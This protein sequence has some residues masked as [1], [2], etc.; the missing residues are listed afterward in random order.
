MAPPASWRGY[1][2]QKDRHAVAEPDQEEDVDD[3][4][5]DP[6]DPAGQPDP[7]EIGDPRV[8][9]YRGLR[10]LAAESCH[11]DAETS[12]STAPIMLHHPRSTTG[13]S[14]I[15]YLRRCL[16]RSRRGL[17]RRRNAVT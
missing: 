10:V 1:P 14:K 4:P 3:A 13:V 15:D 2:V 9:A 11:M 16:R 8:P 12:H 17:C 6:G 7:A 5:Q